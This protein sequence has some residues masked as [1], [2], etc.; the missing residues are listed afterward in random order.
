MRLNRLAH[1]ICLAFFA[2]AT[3][4]QADV[5]V[6]VGAPPTQ[7]PGWTLNTPQ[8]DAVN[9]PADAHGQPTV[10]LFWPSWCPFSRALQPYVQTIW[11]DYRGVVNVWTINILEN[12]DPVQVMKDRG[13]SF[14]LLIDGDPLRASYKITRTPWLVV[15]DGKNNIVYTRPASPP[16]P[17]AVAK[18]VRKT[19]NG[20]L[21]PKAVPLPTSYPKPYTLHL[22]GRNRSS[23]AAQ[24]KPPAPTAAQWQP[25]LKAYIAGVKPGET[26]A[27]EA[28]RGPVPDGKTAI[29]IARKIW[30]T[31]YSK[32]LMIKQAPHRAYRQDNYWVVVGT[33]DS[34]K[35]GDGLILVIT[36]DKG[37]V[38]RVTDK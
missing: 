1:C 37:R 16:T 2:L 5:V 27:G 21:G 31:R 26:V 14:P 6:P 19:L 22:K 12:A 24:P 35:L 15:I 3:T 18:K 32:K 33:T 13:L 23:E 34:G 4:A 17:I 10:L 30:T 28:P 25:W 8:G 9:F 11:E 36:A 20:L 38:V 29:N 7:A